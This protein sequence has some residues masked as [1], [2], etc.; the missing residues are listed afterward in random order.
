MS[1]RAGRAGHGGMIRPKC[2][3]PVESLVVDRDMRGTAQVVN[4]LDRRC[5]PRPRDDLS[6]FTGDAGQP[7]PEQP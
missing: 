5:L 4:D 6:G 3:V 7:S 2:R 1:G